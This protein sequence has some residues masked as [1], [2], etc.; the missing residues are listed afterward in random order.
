VWLSSSGRAGFIGEE[1]ALVRYL[2]C[3]GGRSLWILIECRGREGF[4]QV[5]LF[6]EP[7]EFSL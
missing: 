2:R 5:G 6:F 1:G 3:R 7:E 4:L